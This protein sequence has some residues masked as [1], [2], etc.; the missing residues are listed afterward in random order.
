MS[1]SA[2]HRASYEDRMN[3]IEVLLK[4]RDCKNGKSAGV[5]SARSPGLVERASR[6]FEEHCKNVPWEVA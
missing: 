1:I 6:A 3:A 4:Y 2:L 5:G